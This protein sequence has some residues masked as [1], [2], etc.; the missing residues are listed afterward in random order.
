[1]MNKYIVLDE[2]GVLLFFWNNLSP[3]TVLFLHAGW[4]AF[5][6]FFFFL[7][8]EI[9]FLSQYVSISSAPLVAVNPMYKQNSFC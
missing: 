7:L 6:P 4:A 1:M 5:Q 9:L 2:L 8:K 3:L